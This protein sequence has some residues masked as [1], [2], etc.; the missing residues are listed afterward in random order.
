M[1]F[2]A[3]SLFNP[4]VLKLAGIAPL[5]VDFYGQGGEKNKGVDKGAKQHTRGRKRSITNRSMS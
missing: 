2:L 5:L 3:E 4:V 1:L